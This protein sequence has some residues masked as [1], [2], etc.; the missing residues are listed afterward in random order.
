MRLYCGNC[1]FC[2]CCCNEKDFFKNYHQCLSARN[3]QWR[4]QSNTYKNYEEKEIYNDHISPKIMNNLDN[5]LNYV[6][7]KKY[8]NNV[9]YLFPRLHNSCPQLDRQQV[10]YSSLPRNFIYNGLRQP[11]TTQMRDSYCTHNNI[12]PKADQF[13]KTLVLCKRCAA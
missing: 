2:K 12:E 9:K 13:T 11:L 8:E 3:S 6:S 10:Q 7:E 1:S 5:S 4:D